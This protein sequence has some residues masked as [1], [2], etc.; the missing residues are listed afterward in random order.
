MGIEPTFSQYH[1]S[2]YVTQ[3]YKESNYF[4]TFEL[5]IYEHTSN[6]KI[7]SDNIFSSQDRI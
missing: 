3:L 5:Q 1:I 7:I 4:Y 2:K 6:K